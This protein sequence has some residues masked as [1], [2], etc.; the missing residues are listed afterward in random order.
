MRETPYERS[1]SYNRSHV[2]LVSVEMNVGV[3][4]DSSRIRLLYRSKSYRQPLSSVL[5]TPL[6]TGVGVSTMGP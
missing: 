6:G 4:Q 3:S 5:R 1:Y 2:L